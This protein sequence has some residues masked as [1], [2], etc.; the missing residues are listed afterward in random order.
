MDDGT[1]HRYNPQAAGFA[2]RNDT[3]RNFDVTEVDAGRQDR[4]A[5][6]DIHVTVI[7]PTA[8]NS[9]T[10]KQ[11]RLRSSALFEKNMT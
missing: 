6:R 4:R 2:I 7:Q 11:E 9:D 8:V 3:V 10:I 1:V 5:S